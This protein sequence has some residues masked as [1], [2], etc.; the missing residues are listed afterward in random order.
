MERTLNGVGV[1]AAVV[2]VL[3]CVAAGVL[4]LLGHFHFQG[5]ETMTLFDVGVAG[6]LVAAV[7]RLYAMPSY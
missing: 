4:R 2:G 7:A 5:F 6:L 3:L 1:L